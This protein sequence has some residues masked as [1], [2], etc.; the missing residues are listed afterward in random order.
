M[1]TFETTTQYAWLPYNTVLKKHFKSPNPAL[2]VMRWNEP[3]ATDTISSDTPTIDGGEMYAQIFIGTKTLITDVYAMKSPAQFPGTLSD[4]ITAH[5]VPMKLISDRA[6][7]E[8]SKKVQEILH[9]LYIGSWQSEPH[10][11][12]QNPAERHYQDVKWM[13]NT[14]LGRTGT[15]AYCWLLCLYYICFVLNN[16]YSNSLKGTPL[17]HCTGVTNN[18]SPLLC[19]DFYEPVYFHM[20]DTPFP[21]ASKELRGRWVGISANVSNFMTFKVLTDDMLKVIHHS[22]V[23][24]VCDPTSKILRLDPLNENFPEVITSL[25]QKPVVDSDSTSPDHGEQ[26]APMQHSNSFSMAIIDPQDHVGRTFLMDTRDDGQRFCAQIVEYIDE[27]MHN[28]H[29]TPEH[30][31][32]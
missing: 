22:N 17:R 18:I 5:G 13:V 19:F 29:R 14:V 11:Q 3:V 28:C 30:M 12:H 32:F 1:H 23:R 27:H 26:Q 8:I 25:R 15:P 31:K 24:S 6:Q 9:T 20:D 2:N 4:N 16:L 10:H 7:V 21:S